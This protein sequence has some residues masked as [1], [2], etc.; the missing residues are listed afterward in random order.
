MVLPFFVR[1]SSPLSRTPR[2]KH[3]LL[4]PLFYAR[5]PP[6]LADGKRRQKTGQKV[7]AVDELLLQINA[8]GG[9]VI[10]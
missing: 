2:G 8:I 9:I 1:G 7:N 3:F 4:A 6:V 10:L 5:L